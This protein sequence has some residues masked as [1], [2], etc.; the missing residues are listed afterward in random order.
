MFC[1]KNN[2]K[3][4]NV[5]RKQQQQHN[6]RREDTTECETIVDYILTGASK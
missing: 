4:K 1:A 5:Y 2:L 6:C 3:I